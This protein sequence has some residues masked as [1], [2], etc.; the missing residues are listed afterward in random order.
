MVK[1]WNAHKLATP[2]YASLIDPHE[3]KRDKNEEEEEDEED[4]FLVLS[5]LVA[6]LRLADSS[7]VIDSTIVS[8]Q[9][10][11]RMSTV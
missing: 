11:E 7:L 10:L 1:K 3:V 5:G 2:K 4:V 9:T 6:V 8:Q